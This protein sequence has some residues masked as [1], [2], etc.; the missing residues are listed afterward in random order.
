MTP[1]DQH[2]TDQRFAELFDSINSSTRPPDEA[3]LQRL[4]EETARVFEESA[5][6][7]GKG[8]QAAHGTPDSSEA[9]RESDAPSPP[10]PLPEGEGRCCGTE[11]KE[12]TAWRTTM[13]VFSPRVLVA[14]AAAVIVAATVWMTATADRS[15][16]KLAAVLD[17]IGRSKTVRLTVTLG[18]K[19]IKVAAR[20]AELVRWDYSP[21]RY[22]IAHAERFW[23][24]DEKANRA[25]PN[26]LPHKG[27]TG[28]ELDL[29]GF[30]D[31][32]GYKPGSAKNTKNLRSAGPVEEVDEEGAACRHYKM[33]LTTAD[34][35]PIRLA[36]SVEV[37]SG[38]LRWIEASRTR[39]GRKEPLGRL[40][41]VA[42]D[43]DMPEE[44][45][46]VGDTLTPDGRIGK[47]TDVQG[48]VSLRP[49]MY[50]RWTPI[51]GRA[52]LR[53]GDWL[54]TDRRG[55]NAVAVRL[56]PQTD[57]TL[58]PGTLVELIGPDRFRLDSGEVKI[59]ATEKH[60][61]ELLGPGE[62]KIEVKST[63]IFR[64]D[65]KKLVEL[66]KRPLWL[67]GFEGT[68]N[69]ETLG[70]LV[71][72]V[73]GRDVPLSVG[74]HKVTVDIRDQIARTV[75]EESFV[76]HTDT[77]TE[78]VFRFPLP[79]DASIS[80][81]G[82]WVGDEL[83]E[84]DIV[85]KQRAREIFETLVR[86]NRD[87]GLLEWTGGNV[88]KAR[89]FPIEPHSEKRVRIVYT[90]VLP[91]RGNQYRYSYALQSE[92]LRQHPLRELDIDV[93]VHSVVPLAAV[94]SP[95]HTTRDRK[96]AH[97]ARVE[98]TAQ[99]YT[100]TSDFEVLVEL[101]REAS[102][103]T[104]LPHRRGED[105]YFMLQVA[106]PVGSVSAR[107]DVLPDGEPLNVLILVDTSGSMDP[108]SR[109]RQA[110]LVAALLGSL[111][112]RDRVN[113]ATCDVEC[114]WAFETA[115]PVDDK[116]VAAARDF[117]DKRGSLGWTDLDRAFSSAMKQ[118][119]QVKG[120]VQLIYLGDGIVTGKDSDPVRFADRLK[121]LA[122]GKK[123]T[124]HAVSVSSRYESG[125]LRAIGSLGGGTV[126][127]VSGA[128][129]P[130][131]VARELLAEI[132]R[133]GLREMT[134]EFTGLR[135]ARV[136]PE[137]LPNLPAGSQQ[138][139]LGRYLPEEENQSVEVTV[140][141]LL[142]GR[143]VYWKTGLTLSEVNPEKGTTW[144]TSFIPRLWAR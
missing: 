25:T 62:T 87:P 123:V 143:E 17:Q 24:V 116:T 119:E 40:T 102:T 5:A 106:P 84:A 12:T 58:G 2:K 132:T 46:V 48:L 32:P 121:K 141:G 75:I 134:V 36:V 114:R 50:Q 16:K 1:D 73:D 41:V 71:A 99:Q 22:D 129:G 77:R 38:Q 66:T 20:G 27:L 125:V 98:F 61:V 101:A 81:F 39:N 120:N 80:G 63:R 18:E 111:S 31:L 19:T 55:A 140:R 109:V 130:A 54:R 69:K 65:G 142:D 8:G 10:A 47:V 23:E 85:E 82:M 28:Y 144:D 92:M 6:Q 89:V 9:L 67:Q 108:Q 21:G 128:D 95:T 34:E 3:F 49:V 86:E 43:E 100:P 110:E 78:G 70:S 4:G 138:I 93:T 33:D 94:H 7:A 42:L 74:Y 105:G 133:P 107:A 135:V 90:Q 30:L 51:D 137:V 35:T 64:L 117:L 52:L 124:G 139:L 13:G 83:V 136:Y 68:T 60:P 91:R 45:F 115:Q 11:T 113:L 122:Q 14:A 56:A 15:A 57:V 76:N 127:E 79:Q 104:L 37:K 126:R 96:T 72:K 131:S 59:V 103:V 112:P 53:P 88:F 29:V 44:L 118:A 26:P 97:S